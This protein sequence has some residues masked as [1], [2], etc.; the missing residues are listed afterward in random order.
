M[1]FEKKTRL[2][3]LAE[4]WLREDKEGWGRLKE[5]RSS[6]TGLL[7]VG[8]PTFASIVGPR[9]GGGMGNRS[10]GQ[11]PGKLWAGRMLGVGERRVLA[12]AG[13]QLSPGDRGD[14]GQSLA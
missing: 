14:A 11:R 5:D 7:C 12:G 8:F 4:L 3:C 13:Y 9:M 1:L 6:I 10:R 2:E